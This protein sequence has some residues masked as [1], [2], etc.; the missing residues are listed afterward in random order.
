MT[1]TFAQVIEIQIDGIE[2]NSR[3]EMAVGSVI[4]FI[5]T[6]N[7]KVN[8]GNV[9]QICEI[10]R[11]M[12]IQSVVNFCELFQS[13]KASSKVEA[14]SASAAESG[15]LYSGKF[16]SKWIKIGILSKV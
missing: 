16:Q 6:G 9:S 8:L 11:I 13:G 10:A 5:Y 14:I 1:F 2:T 3:Y 7:L 12:Q 15:N 4:D